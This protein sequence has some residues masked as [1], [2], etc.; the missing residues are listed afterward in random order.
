MNSFVYDKKIRIS[1][2]RSR[3]DKQWINQELYWSEFVYK[4]SNPIKTEESFEEFK[5]MPKSVQDNLKDVGGYVGGELKDN[6]RANGNLL[7]RY[8]VTLDADNIAS[9]G[10]QDIINIVAS[11]GCAYVIYSTR[12]HENIKPRL[13][14]VFPL[15]RPCTP[16]E[17]EPIAR[18]IA[19]Y[20]G[21]EI[22]DPTTFEPIRLMYWASVSTD[23]EFVFN[24]A[25]K[26][27]IDTDGILKQYN[28]WQDC[29][30]WAT[31]PQEKKLREKSIKKQG[32][33]LEKDGLIGAFCKIYNVE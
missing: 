13:R 21:M 20:I 31:V 15:A 32:I 23:S 28:N 24:Y 3:K 1:T 14:I 29:N 27:F 30:E 22:F 10:T 33:T 4:L 11:L 25:D 12:K 19:S 16:D 5:K 8:I 6:I 9:G 26:Y 7:S 18:K 17:Y 2:G